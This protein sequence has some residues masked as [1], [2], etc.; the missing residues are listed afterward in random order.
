MD[1][2]AVTQA[3]SVKYF[4]QQRHIRQGISLGMKTILASRA[5]ILMA[6]GEKKA[7]IIATTV[8][9]APDPAVPATLLKPHPRLRIIVDKAAAAKL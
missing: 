7:D 3:V 5:I 1:L 8:N 9:S 2:D 6:S 4:G